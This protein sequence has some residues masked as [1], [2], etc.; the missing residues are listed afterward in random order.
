VKVYSVFSYVHSDCFSHL[1]SLANAWEE[2]DEVVLITCRLENPDL[3]MA[4]G[5]VNEKLENFC[6]E[7]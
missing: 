2:D 3:D 5:T 7:L 1:L 6:N 4:S